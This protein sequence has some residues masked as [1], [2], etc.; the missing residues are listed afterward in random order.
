MATNI[1]EW[2][3]EQHASR[4]LEANLAAGTLSGNFNT[5]GVKNPG[6]RYSDQADLAA[7]MD[8]RIR[9]W[10]QEQELAR[11]A[12]APLASGAT[13]AQVMA[14]ALAGIQQSADAN[15]QAL[16]QLTTLGQLATGQGPS[17][18]GAAASG[19]FQ[20]D[21]ARQAALASV[22]RNASLR[23]GTPA[24]LQASGQAGAG[25]LQ[26]VAQ[27]Q[28]AYG[29]ALMG[30]NGVL[31]NQVRTADAANAAGALGLD[32]Q[33]TGFNAQ[34]AV[35]QQTN[36]GNA[37]FAAAD[38]RAKQSYA[39]QLQDQYR[40]GAQFGAALIPGQTAAA[41]AAAAKKERDDQAVYNMYGGLVG[42]AGSLIGSA[43]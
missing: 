9:A 18:A 21:F 19:Q 25:R 6:E 17:A 1:P 30:K 2:A 14:P 33:K 29:N 3:R 4:L 43:L 42:A 37:L 39:Q 38:Q 10:H 34:N 27:A 23:A 8:P 35:A 28:A 5:T 32:L 15:Q 40:T 20:Q 16:G 36:T 12:A 22:N 13:S 31:G 41:A 11:Q 26:E 7:S 24:A